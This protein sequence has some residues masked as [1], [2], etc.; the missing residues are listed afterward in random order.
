MH[1][2]QGLST[3]AKYNYD[4]DPVLVYECMLAHN[5]CVYGYVHK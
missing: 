4:H 1:I 2:L 3:I 5:V